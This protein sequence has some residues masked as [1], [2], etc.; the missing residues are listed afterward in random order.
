MRP[1]PAERKE[2]A[3]GYYGHKTLIDGSHVPLTKDEAAAIMEAVMV[4]NQER[5]KDMPAV[6]DAFAALIRAWMVDHARHEDEAYRAM[7]D[8]YV[9]GRPMEREP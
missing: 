6:R 5:A 3:T 2:M 8:R 4:A 9:T 7:L 1:M